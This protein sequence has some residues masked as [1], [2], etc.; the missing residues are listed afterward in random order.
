MI[1][2][3]V[4]DFLRHNIRWQE[5]Y[6][7]ATTLELPDGTVKQIPNPNP[8]NTQALKIRCMMIKEGVDPSEEAHI[9]KV[10]HLSLIF[11]V[12]HQDILFKTGWIR[13]ND[14][15]VAVLREELLRALHRFFHTFPVPHPKQVSIDAVISEASRIS[16]EGDLDAT[17]NPRI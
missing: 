8:P 17:G 1:N 4:I 9:S 7:R 10:F 13:L 11:W 12:H 3:Q 5:E 16:K 14:G 15:V 6:A 2:Y